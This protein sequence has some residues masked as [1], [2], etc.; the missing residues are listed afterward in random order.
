MPYINIKSNLLQPIGVSTSCSGVRSASAPPHE[1]GSQTCFAPHV[2]GDDS[3]QTLYNLKPARNVFYE[4]CFIKKEAR[5][6]C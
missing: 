2:N 6:P 1:A 5:G 4:M 3:Q